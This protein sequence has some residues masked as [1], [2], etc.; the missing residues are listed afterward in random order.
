MIQIKNVTKKFP[1]VTALDNI[2]L[3]I[4]E[5]EFFGLLGPNGAGKTTLMNLLVGYLNPEQGEIL[6][7]GETVTQDGLQTRKNIG[8]VPQSLALYDDVSAEANLEIFGSFF[9]IEKKLMKERI[10]EML[11]SVELYD[12]RKD[13]V[14]TFSGGMK[15]RLNLVASLLHD[16][17]LLL[18]DEPTVGVD[19]QS[20]NAIF[21]YLEMLNQQGKTIV[22]TTHYM[23]EA[24]RLCN[25]IAIIDFG[26]IIAEGTLD[27]L[28][29]KLTY[30]ESIT[31]LRNPTTTEKI[32]LFK[33][34]GTLIDED[35]H[36]ELK[37]KDGFQLSEFFSAVEQ[38]GISYKFIEMHKPTLEALFLHLTGRRLRD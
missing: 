15:R 19:P 3:A 7:A 2:S 23:E 30:E 33:Q 8:L 18:C 11:E 38:N 13:K 16:P 22:Y 34:F 6:I 27:H 17:P 20:R 21:D 28:L 31:I 29:E 4:R 14:K 1:T 24:E 10:K 9:H 12:R 32:E 35:D 26:K 25:R 37:P 5:K 36:Y